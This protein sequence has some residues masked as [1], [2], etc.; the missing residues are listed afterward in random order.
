[1]GSRRRIPTQNNYV[2]YEIED[3]EDDIDD[4]TAQLLTPQVT[5]T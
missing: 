3:Q 2:K 5:L 4:T 1:M